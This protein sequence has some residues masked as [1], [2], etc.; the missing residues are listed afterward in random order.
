MK[1]WTYTL[2]ELFRRPGRTLLTLAG[3]VI[4]VAA[5]TAVLMTSQATRQAAREMFVSV[6]GKADLEVTPDG[7]GGFPP[8]VLV[9]LRS[10][11][12]VKKAVPALRVPS[13][14]KGPGARTPVLVLGVD[15]AED[16]Q[17][18]E[19]H[20]VRGDFLGDAPGLLLPSNLAEAQ[21]L[22][23]GSKAE[24][25][26][27][28][29]GLTGTAVS[30]P[31]VG[32]LEPRGA[33]AFNGGGVVFLPL[34][35]A[36]KL[37]GFGEQI[38]N[39]QLLLDDG[40][41]PEEVIARAE[42]ELR[43]WP[44]LGVQKPAQRGELMQE[45]LYSTEQGLATI[46]LVSLVAGAFVI[47]NTFLMSLGERHRQI[48]I[49][50]A[51][52]ATRK[53]VT[54]L[55][56][57]EAALLGAAGTLLGLGGGLLLAQVLRQVMLG[58]VN[59]KLPEMPLSW[60]PFAVALLLGPGMSLAATW[61][62]ARAAGRRPPLQGLGAKRS[63][64]ATSL[65]A[66]TRW[67]GLLLLVVPLL[68][69]AS[70]LGRWL[71]PSWLSVMV[72]PGLA[73]GMVGCVLCLPMVLGPLSRAVAW[74]LRPLLGVEGKLAFRQLERQPVRTAL[75]VGVLFVGT[76]V[77]L[78]FGN[79]LLNNVRKI[80][81]WHDK[82]I[83]A[84]FL[85]RGNMP[86]S[87]FVV[88][89]HLPEDTGQ[90]IVEE[91]PGIVR[92]DKVAFVLGKAGRGEEKPLSAVILARG[93]PEGPLERLDVV[94]GDPADVIPGLRRGEVV[95]GT[96]LARR[97][98][99]TA[100]DEVVLY[101][102]DG[103]RRFRVAATATD[104]T[105]G[106]M[107]AYVEYDVAKPLFSIPGPHALEVTAAKDRD[108][109]ETEAALR[110]YC[111]D[112]DLFLQTNEELRAM[113]NGVVGQVEGFLYM[114]IALLFV[115]ASLGVVNTLTMNVLEQTRELG[116]LRAVGLRRRQARK[117]VLAQALLMAGV[118]TIPGVVVGLVLALLMNL[119]TEPLLG[120]RV[121][122]RVDLVYA[123]GC[124]LASVAVAV[125]AGLIPA[126]QAARLP[127]IEALHYE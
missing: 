69:E 116:V 52:G 89:A 59:L 30:V 76:A 80:H 14:L 4:G 121:P 7:M 115:V 12:G 63:A 98:G 22:D 18:R 70:L 96:V 29:T 105:G 78:G 114:L 25:T 81:D 20:L 97:L 65:P 83:V 39:V 109:A 72:A 9:K 86:D 47:L 104:Y 122:F 79:S 66:W 71:P 15:P 62:P 102:S 68:V 44:G 8:D 110:Q 119:A 64:N 3:I 33:A 45:V 31:V 92:A 2:R 46:S 124:V 75:T 107:S 24:L 16:R 37:F 61:L 112:H 125:V 35:Q 111:Q 73:V 21:G 27:P 10:T 93:F 87:T 49:L 48:A 99:V 6:T 58:V 28:L 34:G 53:Q 5:V 95:L 19:Y 67:L 127:V 117:M 77:S 103:P 56:V 51:L 118:S 82:T 1:M 74:L 17:V 88:V 126:R 100:G 84:D 23:V 43:P 36:Q 90:K 54:S 106:G 41:D 26:T 32:V 60:E 50:R 40:A 108:R 57:R 101:A 42:K 13:V 55:L 38:N 94:D 120:Q 11:P 85:V 91:V 113:V 123:V